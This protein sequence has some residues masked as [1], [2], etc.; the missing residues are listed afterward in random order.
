MA[1]EL[2]AVADTPVGI[3]GTT[4]A[5]EA[6]ELE[7]DATLLIAFVAVTTQRIVLPTSADTNVY[8]LEVAPLILEPALCH[9]YAYSVI[10][11]AAVQV[12]FVVLKVWPNVAVPVTAGATVLEGGAP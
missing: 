3:P 7:F 8:V 9:W 12:P 1:E 10:G 11:G 5:T 4:A 6:V 2:V